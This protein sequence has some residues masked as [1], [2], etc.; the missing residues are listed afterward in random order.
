MRKLL[1]PALTRRNGER[2]EAL[3]TESAE[4]ES[5]ELQALCR[6]GPARPVPETVLR[7]ARA[8]LGHGREDL[9]PGTRF[10]ELGGDSLSTLTFAR[11]L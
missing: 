11:L 8:L 7:A 9:H 1:R 2:L 3:Y 4:R 10:L 6:E 5:G